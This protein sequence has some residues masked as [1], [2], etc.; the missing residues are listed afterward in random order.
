MQK[1]GTEVWLTLGKACF[2]YLIQHTLKKW[3]NC[4]EGGR[5]LHAY[6]ILLLLTPALAPIQTKL[7]W[8]IANYI[9]NCIFKSHSE[10]AGSCRLCHLAWVQKTGSSVQTGI[11]LSVFLLCTEVYTFGLVTWVTWSFFLW[12]LSSTSPKSSPLLS[13]NKSNL[14]RIPSLT[15][16]IHWGQTCYCFWWV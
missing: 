5:V 11:Q 9:A 3:W 7:I 2:S 6:Y 4:A 13:R 14:P 1:W 10:W 16:K 8:K 15:V 12:G